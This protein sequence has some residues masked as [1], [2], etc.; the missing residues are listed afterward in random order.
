MGNT[1]LSFEEVDYMEGTYT[2][3]YENGEISKTVTFKN[4]Q[5]NGEASFYYKNGQL[6]MNGT[7]EDGE[8][9]GKWNFYTNDGL[10]ASGDWN[11]KFKVQDQLF[12]MDGQL[13]FGIPY[14]D[15]SILKKENGRISRSLVLWNAE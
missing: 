9:I 2:T 15:W 6:A 4:N 1:D 7:F 3:Q 5:L 14:G 11:W 13:A 8:M 12:T 10:I